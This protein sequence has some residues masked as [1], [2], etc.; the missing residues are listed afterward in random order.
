MY[1]YIFLYGFL[2]A[3]CILRKKI[4]SAENIASSVHDS[5]IKNKNYNNLNEIAKEG[6]YSYFIPKGKDKVVFS[7]LRFNLSMTIKNE[8]IKNLLRSLEADE[9]KEIN[10]KNSERLINPLIKEAKKE[11]EK[12]VI[13]DSYS[14]INN[15]SKDTFSIKR[16]N[17]SI[18]IKAESKTKDSIATN[19]ILISKYSEG[20]YVSIYPYIFNSISDIKSTVI[21]AFPVIFLLI[22]MIVF[23]LNKIYSK[24]ITQPILKM[25]NFT[26]VSKNQK[27]AKYDLEIHT[28]DEIEELSN[29]LKLLYETLT[30]NYKILEKNTKKKKSSSNLHLTNWRHLFKLLFYWMI[31]WLKK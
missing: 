13:I 17:N 5:F 12:Y 22:V 3:Q 9:F 7:G 6:M 10:S 20:T 31:V 1:Y 2:Y 30:E 15:V 26:K 28:N 14:N 29:N 4:E 18:L 21:S 24:S 11:L 25:N 19:L 16:K 8:N 27:N 23:L